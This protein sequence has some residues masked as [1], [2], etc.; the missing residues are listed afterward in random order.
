MIQVI[1]ITPPVR[2]ASLGLAG[3][4]DAPEP[5]PGAALI[6]PF[7]DEATFRAH[8]RCQPGGTYAIM[9]W[10]GKAPGSEIVPENIRFLGFVN[11][12]A[13]QEATEPTVSLRKT[14]KAPA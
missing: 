5:S 1:E 12:V 7:E 11:A 9:E 6:G 2:S 4:E 3:D 13:R 14:K 10:E 8:P